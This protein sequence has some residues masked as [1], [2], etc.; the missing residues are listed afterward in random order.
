MATK[1]RVRRSTPPLT[2]KQIDAEGKYVTYLS[3]G[4]AMRVT[5]VSQNRIQNWYLSGHIRTVPS[6]RNHGRGYALV[7]IV[8]IRLLTPAQRRERG[9]VLT[10]EAYQKLNREWLQDQQQKTLKKADQHY[11]RWD[12]FD[13]EF[14]LEEYAKGTP[15]VMIARMLGRTFHATENQ[16]YKLRHE[17]EE[18]PKIERTEDPEW[19]TRSLALLTAD[20]IASL[21]E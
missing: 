12:E 15:C 18:L 9:I 3:L 19:K 11:E 10:P 7:D 20:E 16:I 17:L 14:I 6:V 21:L 5:D 8:R 13:N 2:W 4:E 1:T